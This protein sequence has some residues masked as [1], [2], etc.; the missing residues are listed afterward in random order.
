MPTNVIE[1]LRALV[2]MT[3]EGWVIDEWVITKQVAAIVQPWVDEPIDF[4]SGA[5]LVGS[6][7][8]T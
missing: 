8:A 4:A 1:H 3:P 2:E 7:Q 6:V 5:W